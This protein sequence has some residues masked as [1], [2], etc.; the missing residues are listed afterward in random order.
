[1]TVANLIPGLPLLS[2][3]EFLSQGSKKRCQY[4][5]G[6]ILNYKCPCIPQVNQPPELKDRDWKQNRPPVIQV[7]VLSDLV[8]HLRT[9]KSMGLDGIHPGVLRELVEELVKLPSTIYHQS[10]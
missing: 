8:S 10:W 5:C 3:Q 7:E 1:M 9:H 6:D 4:L 2:Y